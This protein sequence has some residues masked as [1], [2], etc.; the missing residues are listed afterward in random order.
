MTLPKHKKQQINSHV[1]ETAEEM[2]PKQQEKY[3]K[4]AIEIETK[5]NEELDNLL[6]QYRV[7][8]AP[9]AINESPITPR[10]NH[11]T[12][13]LSVVAIRQMLQGITSPLATINN[14]ALKVLV[15]E[16]IKLSLES[17]QNAAIAQDV[18]LDEVIL[19]KQKQ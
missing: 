16:T 7:E 2:S 6:A 8:A 9:F 17:I 19:E 14:S 10:K 11:E 5:L 18:L 15:L 1:N 3:K 4:A 12:I 13:E